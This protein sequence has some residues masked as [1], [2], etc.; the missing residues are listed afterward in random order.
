MR[1]LTLKVQPWLGITTGAG[2]MDLCLHYGA[3]MLGIELTVSCDSNALIESRAS[4]LKMSASPSLPNP[5]A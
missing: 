4:R 2:R 1:F 3:V 5:S